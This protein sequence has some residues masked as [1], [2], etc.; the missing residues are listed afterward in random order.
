LAARTCVLLYALDL[1]FRNLG[2]SVISAIC[3]KVH[4]IY[5][6]RGQGVITEGSPGNEFYM[7][8]VGELEVLR[9]NAVDTI[10]RYKM[11]SQPRWTIL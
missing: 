9:S 4:P 3:S 10:R 8:L 11:R 5:V 2:N 1:M 7:M 6:L